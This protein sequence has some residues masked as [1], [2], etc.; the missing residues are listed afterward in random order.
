MAIQLSALRDALIDA[1]ASPQKAGEAAAEVGGYKNRLAGLDPHLAILTW[2][3]VAN[4]TLTLLF[5]GAV[6]AVWFKL[7]EVCGQLA[8]ASHLH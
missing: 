2:I 3:M 7:G 4:F 6:F 1:G 8:F 5:G